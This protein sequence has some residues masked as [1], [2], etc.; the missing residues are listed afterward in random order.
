MND[1]LQCTACGQSLDDCRCPNMSD[2]ELAR[3]AAVVTT[4]NCKPAPMDALPEEDEDFL[5]EL[6]E[7]GSD[8]NSR[9]PIQPSD[10][11]ILEDD[12]SELFGEDSEF[13]DDVSDDEFASELTSDGADVRLEEPLYPDFV[14][15]QRDMGRLARAY[16]DDAVS[17][18]QFS[19]F[20]GNCEEDKACF[21]MARFER[22]AEQLGEDTR[23]T[24][25]NALDDRNARAYGDQ[26]QLFK[27][28]CTPGFWST[29]ADPDAVARFAESIPEDIPPEMEDRFGWECLEVARNVREK[30]RK[31]R[32]DWKKEGF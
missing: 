10:G 20:T 32:A 5:R 15:D 25:I 8:T 7:M 26:W 16:L 9:P 13:L 3:I 28:T 27:Y 30:I 1:L 6:E 12:D 21:H 14:L 23:L 29:Q 18:F 22:V 31:E 4:S 19:F 24:I 2:R 17:L 11:E